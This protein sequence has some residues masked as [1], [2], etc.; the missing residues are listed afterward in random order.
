MAPL[1]PGL[2]EL[3]RPGDPAGAAR[4]GR[5]VL[6]LRERCSGAPREHDATQEHEHR[7]RLQPPSD[8]FG[9][10]VLKSLMFGW[11]R[12]GELVREKSGMPKLVST[13]FQSIFG[14]LPESV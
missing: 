14:V 8:F 9:C 12:E 6:C 11:L 2:H 3:A 4:P 1:T 7:R 5:Q 13:A 10:S